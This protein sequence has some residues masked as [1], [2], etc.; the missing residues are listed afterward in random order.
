MNRKR[1]EEDELWAKAF[2]IIAQKDAEIARLKTENNNYSHNV[3]NLTD[4]IFKMQKLI[5]MQA[6]MIEQLRK[7][8]TE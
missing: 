7:G 5:E 2:E 3:R 6:K 1:P 4:S 8:D